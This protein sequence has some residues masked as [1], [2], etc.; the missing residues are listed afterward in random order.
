MVNWFMWNVQVLC[1]AMTSINDK[2]ILFHSFLFSILL[3]WFR[4]RRP[5]SMTVDTAKPFGAIIN[6]TKNEC[7][8]SVRQRN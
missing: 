3:F 8:N 4:R 2:P 5:S 1:D 7:F 6:K